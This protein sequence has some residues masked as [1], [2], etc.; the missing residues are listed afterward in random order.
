MIIVPWFYYVEFNDMEY[1]WSLMSITR[2]S[3]SW[4]NFLMVAFSINM[5]WEFRLEFIGQ[6]LSLKKIK[7]RY[8][9]NSNRMNP[10]VWT[11]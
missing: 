7:S 1:G 11:V 4:N 2:M 3:V 5:K 8:N 10:I 9:S 6:N